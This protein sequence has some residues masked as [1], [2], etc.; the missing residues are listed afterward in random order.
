MAKIGRAT[1]ESRQ[2]LT[3]LR[4]GGIRRPLKQ[5]ELHGI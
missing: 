3:V 2:A 1:G 5:A 4:H